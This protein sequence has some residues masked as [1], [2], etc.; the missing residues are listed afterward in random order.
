MN[1]AV[2]ENKS[3]DRSFLCYLLLGATTE[4]GAG[5]RSC[6][7]DIRVM[8]AEDDVRL[9]LIT[10]VCI[11]YEFHGQ[12]DATLHVLGCQFVPSVVRAFER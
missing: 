11:V 10:A 3:R 12:V 2:N 7:E 5:G 6:Q 1:L 9:L 8:G 4:I